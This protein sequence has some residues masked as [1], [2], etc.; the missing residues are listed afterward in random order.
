MKLYRH[1]FGGL[2]AITSMNYVLAY[3]SIE[4]GWKR[5]AWNGSA[6]KLLPDLR[7]VGNN[8]KLK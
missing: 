7:L 8:F 5:S 1:A 6:D 3:I 2:F 4:K